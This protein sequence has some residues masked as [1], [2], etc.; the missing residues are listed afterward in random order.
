MSDQKIQGLKGDP[1]VTRREFLA[2]GT[3]LLG[4]VPLLGLFSGSLF[5]LRPDFYKKAW[6][7]RDFSADLVTVYKMVPLSGL[8]YGKAEAHHMANKIFPSIDAARACRPHKGF[9]Y[10]LKAVPLPGALVNGVDGAALFCGRKDLD[11]RIRTDR[12]HW[13]HLGVDIDTVFGVVM[14]NA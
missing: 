5:R 3:K 11:Q 4:F 12:H 7:G 10:G 9:L 14:K 1:E 2:K 13:Q 8:K 6:P